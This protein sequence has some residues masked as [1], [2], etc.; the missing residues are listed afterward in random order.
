MWLRISFTYHTP[1]FR[2]YHINEPISV[3]HGNDLY[4]IYSL[5][6][7]SIPHVHNDVLLYMYQRMQMFRV[8][9]LE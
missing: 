5:N 1:L 3:E 8:S 4:D 7:P 9:G 6:S 2:V